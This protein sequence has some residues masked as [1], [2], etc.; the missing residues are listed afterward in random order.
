MI[1]VNLLQNTH[2]ID[3]GQPVT[4]SSDPGPSVTDITGSDPS[5]SVTDSVVV[6][7]VNL[8]QI[9]LILVICYI[10]Q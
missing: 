6:V 10:Y 1:L 9:V 3:P 2:S 7:L 5:Q 8:L 4:D